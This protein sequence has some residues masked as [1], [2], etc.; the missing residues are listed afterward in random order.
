MKP[1]SAKNKGV[2]LQ[3]Y[4]AERI[5]YLLS[6]E[7]ADIKPAIMGE[8]GRDI[9]LSS[10][11]MG[12]FPYSVECKNTERLSLW[13]AWAQCTENKGELFPLL[14]VKKNHRDPLAVVQF[15][16]FMNLLWS[17]KQSCEDLER[18]E[19]EIKHLTDNYVPVKDKNPIGD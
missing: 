17:L 10:K 15:D 2:R 11:A 9:H 18:A 12:M 6:L 4:V 5:R 8:S 13:S 14:V 1:R 16:H 3:N 7:E 19:K